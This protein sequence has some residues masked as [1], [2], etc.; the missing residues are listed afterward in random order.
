MITPNWNWRYPLTP[1]KNVK[2]IILHHAAASRY[3]AE[4]V[5]NQHRNQTFVNSQG[6][7][8]FW[9]G[10]GY[11]EYIHKDGTVYIG[12]GDHVGGHT[13][14]YN[15]I[16][17]G[18]GC[19]G[20]YD[21]ETM[22]E[23]QLRALRE[24]V[25]CNMTRFNVELKRHS[26][27]NRTSCPGRNFPTDKQILEGDDMWSQK[28]IEFVTEFQK[29]SGL[30]ADGKAGNITFG[31]LNELF[32][33]KQKKY[34]FKEIDGTRI[35]EIEPLALN[36]LSVNATAAN[37]VK[38]YPEFFNGMFFSFQNGRLFCLMVSSGRKIAMPQSYDL[39]QKGTFIVYDNGNVQ[40][41]T[42]R[43]ILD[44]SNIKMA[45][46]GANCDFEVNGSRSLLESMRKEGWCFLKDG[47]WVDNVYSDIC[48]R[49]VLGYDPVVKKVK[50]I[51]KVTDA[52]GIRIEARKH[53][54]IVNGNTAAIILD[55]GQ[56]FAE[57]SDG[58][59]HYGT[60]RIQRN[61]ITF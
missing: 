54:C 48:R 22:P 10:I 16:S 36:S 53:G 58:K 45:V 49:G 38:L 52:M 41:A 34:T 18:I 31:K 28:A 39:Q 37:L 25:K 24:R 15:S 33:V 43:D 4:Q 59:L 40:T 29:R 5:H 17:Y 44:V 8:Q 14:G 11:N 32:P 56:S 42:V 7:T 50:F 3:T 20:N 46:Q 51:S 60:G 19:E 26:D 12:R 23:T 47:R 1:L 9:N 2:Y 61:I 35:Y 57:A 30:V 6:Q 27:F 13:Q 21:T 55:A